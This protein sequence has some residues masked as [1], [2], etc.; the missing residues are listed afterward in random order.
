M[1][2]PF[3][4]SFMWVREVG[5]KR[6]EVPASEMFGHPLVCSCFVRPSVH[7]ALL[8][9]FSAIQVLFCMIGSLSYWSVSEACI[10]WRGWPSFHF[11]GDLRTTETQL[12]RAQVLHGA[13]F[14]RAGERL[15]V[16]YSCVLAADR[17]MS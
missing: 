14:E 11:T 10:L 3:V 2:P 8:F 16:W 4:H 12:P 9:F 15:F 1:S 5:V 13:Q 7:F 6:E 17:T